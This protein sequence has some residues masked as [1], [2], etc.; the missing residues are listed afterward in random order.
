MAG[1]KGKV[2]KRCPGP[3]LIFSARGPISGLATCEIALS[4]YS[5]ARTRLP[6]QGKHRKSRL[7]PIA[8]SLAH[9]RRNQGAEGPKL[10]SVPQIM[11]SQVA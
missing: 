7:R 3:P 9:D 6:C 11:R 5:P 2:R 4:A 1:A 10:D 8:G